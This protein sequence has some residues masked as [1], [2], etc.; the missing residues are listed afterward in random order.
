[1]GWI[2]SPQKDD[3]LVY[4]GFATVPNL[5]SGGQVRFNLGGA[6]SAILVMN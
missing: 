5:C 2:P 3:P 4:Q 6:F 1:M